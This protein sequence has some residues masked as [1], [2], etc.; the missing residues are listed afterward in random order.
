MLGVWDASTPGL[1]PKIKPHTDLM[2][3]DNSL[4]SLWNIGL[5]P[6]KVNLGIA[7]FGRGFTVADKSCMHYDCQFTG[8]NRA[9]S[10]TKLEGA[11]SSC[12]I[13][14]IIQEKRLTPKLMGGG[15][16]IKEI[17]W[18]DQWI[19]FDDNETLGMKLGLANYRCLGGTALWAIDYQICDTRQVIS[20]TLIT[21]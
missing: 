14:R 17:S 13:N 4:K 11:L 1:G 3:I 6:N 21:Y 9:G 2:E 16:N 19:G 18:E 20:S 15:A 8:P 12:E 5:T 10:C 7:N